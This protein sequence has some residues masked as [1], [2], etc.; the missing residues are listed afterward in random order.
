MRREFFLVFLSPLVLVA[1]GVGYIN[2]SRQ[3]GT[4]RAEEVAGESLYREV[5]QTVRERYVVEADEDRL[6]YGAAR[7]IMSE[8]DRHSR[9]YDAVE[10]ADR[11]ITTQGEYV[12]IGV[13]PGRL[14]GVIS[15]IEVFPGSPAERAGVMHGD[16]ILAVDATQVDARTDVGGLL[17]GTRGSEVELTLQALGGGRPRTVTVTRSRTPSRVVYGYLTGREGR[18]GYIHVDSF[19]DN[20]MEMFDSELARLRAA[21]A[22]S[23]ILDLRG[24]L[25]GNLDAAVELA[26][27]FIPGG[28]ITTTSGRLPARSRMAST[29]TPCEGMPLV[30]LVDAYSASASEVVAGALQ[31]HA[32]G[33]L[34]GE[35]T[36]GKGVVQEVASFQSGWPGGMKLTTAHHFTPS[37][38]CI[39]RSI[40]LGK[41]AQRRGGLVPDVP[42]RMAPSLRTR[43]QRGDW[44]AKLNAHRRRGRFDPRVRRI[45]E[46][47]QPRFDDRQ[48]DAAI[49]LLSDRWVGDR[50]LGE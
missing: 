36:F 37:G 38:R 14:R 24:N 40:G 50:P 31:D 3:S 19:R 47:E 49:A 10:W 16:R 39:E 29:S 22:E 6:V 44:Y 48:V 25:G 45:L 9:V 30:V 46:E 7:G 28:V 15:I 2:A 8:L 20:T 33:V 4:R 23:L 12:G 5:L 32:R 35:R 18:V 13:L 11:T 17:Q 42:V 21:G 26:D 27:R 1:I 43:K 34:L 41:D